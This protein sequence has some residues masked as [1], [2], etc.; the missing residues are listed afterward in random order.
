MHTP[1]Q[2]WHGRLCAAYA[3][4]VVYGS[5]V[6]LQ[7]RALPL[8]QAWLAFLHMPWLD[9]GVGSRADWVANGV[10]YAPLG[11]LLALV[12]G[13]GRPRAWAA[14]AAWSC[15]T[16]LAFGVEFLQLF[17]PPRTVSR[18]DLLAEAL[19]A[20]LGAAAACALAPGL[21]ALR[22][23]PG[24]RAELAWRAY[25]AAWL[26]WSLFPFDLLVSARE[27]HEKARS[28]LWG[29]WRVPAAD[30]GPAQAALQAGADLL[31]TVPLGRWVALRLRRRP[32]VPRAAAWGALLGLAVEGAQFLLASG[33][34]QGS[35]VVT[36]AAGL[37]LG[38]WLAPAWAAGGLRAVRHGLD[39]H[40][41]LL[42]GPWLALLILMAGGWGR[43]PW[44]GLERVAASWQALRLQPFYYHYYTSEAAALAS[45]GAVVLAYAPLA[46][47]A[48]ARR[49]SAGGT[50]LL[51]ALL[52]LVVE[53]GKLPL[54]DIHPD[55]TNA[56]VAGAAVWCAVRL[57][58]SWNVTQH[59]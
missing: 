58:V 12:F 25:A 51:A 56:L 47:F 30:T 43:H 7:P 45:V 52:A 17:F 54:Q 53:F 18:N 4:F 22:T 27:L 38:V 44:G 6:P 35:S 11:A 19:G 33:V 9:L 5:L 37:A 1:V 13:A 26:L 14:L 39:R 29:V 8:E 46:A 21:A 40:L 49:A 57:A 59:A 16:L 15:A 32:S 2:G 55:P 10:L 48:W 50:A 24:G 28:G 3:A 23:V 34:S 20:A 36:R 31:M 41:A 42:V